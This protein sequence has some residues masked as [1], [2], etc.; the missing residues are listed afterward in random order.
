MIEQIRDFFAKNRREAY[1]L[2]KYLQ[3][4]CGERCRSSELLRAYDAFLEKNDNLTEKLKG[5]VLEQALTRTVVAIF[6][7]GQVNLAARIGIAKWKY[8]RIFVEEVSAEEMDVREFLSLE[9][10]LEEG[11]ETEEDWTVEID[12]SPFERNFPNLTETRSIGGGVEF[13]NRHLS[14]SVSL[15]KGSSLFN[16]LKLH[17]YSGVQLLISPQMKSVEELQE[18]LRVYIEYLEK[19]PDDAMWLDALSYCPGGIEPGWGRTAKEAKDMMLQ[20]LDIL[21]APDP[22]ALG[23]FLCKIPMISK[24]AIISPHGFFAQSDVLGLPDTGGQVVYILDQVRALEHTIREGLERQGLGVEPNIIVVTR[25][26]PDASG[27][28]CNQRVERITGTKNAKILRVPFREENGEVVRH[29]ISRFDIWPY[30]ERFSRDV[31]KELYAELSGKPDFLIGNYSDGNLVATLLSTSMRTTQ[32]NIAH[33]LE[34]TK[35]FS[36]ALKWK[37]MD[38]DYHFSCQFTADL[39]A[40]NA[41]DFIITSTKQEIVGTEE[42]IGQ[43]ESYSSFTMPGL[44]RVVEGINVFD[45]KFNVISP[46]ADANAYFPWKEKDRRLENLHGRIEEVIYGEDVDSGGARGHLDDRKKPIIFAMSRLD[47]VKNVAGL[48]RWYAENKELQ[49]E[50]YLFIVAGKVDPEKTQ[51]KEELAE[52]KRMHELFDEFGLESCVRWVNAISEKT[53]NGEMYRYIADKRGCFVQPALFEAFGLTVIEAM[54]SGLPVFATRYGG[55][56]EIVRDGICG[57]TIDTTK[58]GEGAERMLKFFRMC[59]ENPSYWDEISEG[60]LRRV[61]EAYTWDLYARRL[62][63]LAQIY[64]F[65]RHITNIEREETQRYL[66]LLY[67]LLFRPLARNVLGAEEGISTLSGHTSSRGGDHSTC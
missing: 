28:T 57:F 67:G 38:P 8:V 52:C 41:A 63:N 15:Q 61:R 12:F 2:L 21:Q 60:A 24:L 30:L 26:I 62:L 43:Y 10:K 35:Y 42:G 54:G 66:E 19:L 44:F 39:I 18:T 31:E 51:D 34:K 9:E 11:R 50:A 23:D 27:T 64:S 65:W 14:T 22:I 59:R 56:S 29:W 7:R 36:S 25:L 5:T 48:T 6:Q 49:E 16:F 32:C 4:A 3:A 20:L 17:Q 53:F 1:T 33:A 45:P 40:M 37:E 13:L 58:D 47:A 55:P 46:G